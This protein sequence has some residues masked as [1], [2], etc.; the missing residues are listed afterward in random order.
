MVLRQR[1]HACGW[2]CAVSA[3]WCADPLPPRGAFWP[4]RMSTACTAVTDH[5]PAHAHLCHPV[6]VLP[7]APAV[8]AAA[9]I[10]G[11]LKL[12]VEPALYAT[13]EDPASGAVALD[14]RTGCIF[15]LDEDPGETT[16]L[17]DVLDT[18]VVDGLFE[19]AAEIE[20]TR[21]YECTGSEVR[22][23]HGAK[24]RH[25]FFDPAALEAASKRG[26]CVSVRGIA[27]SPA[28]GRSS[29]ASAGLLQRLSSVH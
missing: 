5:S 23:L 14:C 7:S 6:V 15:D 13:A 9:L 19:L 26:G 4:R 21:F 24:N 28:R 3:W 12:L 11:R 18:A 25:V 22:Y 16:N 27:A 20:A 17:I 8:H 10:H 2:V 1:A 29:R